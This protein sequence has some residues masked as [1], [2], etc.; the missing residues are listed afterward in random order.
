M[1]KKSEKAPTKVKPKRQKR[2]LTPKEQ[3]ALVIGLVAILLS[4][5][6]VAAL[7]WL[8]GVVG[9]ILGGCGVV[10]GFISLM[11]GKGGTLPSVVAIVAGFLTVL[12]YLVMMQLQ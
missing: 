8:S 5:V 3:T 12:S 4:V 9:A 10:A 6:G 7:L 11:V 2:Q 1:Q